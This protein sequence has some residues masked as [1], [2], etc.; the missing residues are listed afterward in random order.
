MSITEK[1]REV[2]RACRVAGAGFGNS[3][4]VNLKLRYNGPDPVGYFQKMTHYRTI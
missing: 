2:Y 1:H 4:L 3:L